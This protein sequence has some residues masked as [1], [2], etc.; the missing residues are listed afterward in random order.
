[1]NLF[2]QQ[3]MKDRIAVVNEL[4]RT[5]KLD[6]A[7]DAEQA[8]WK[9]EPAAKFVQPKQK[10]P[11]SKAIVDAVAVDLGIRDDMATEWI[12]LAAEELRGEE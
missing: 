7:V 12:I 4:Q 9:Q 10:F 2:E 6:M 5:D 11:G 8:A 3:A 1:M